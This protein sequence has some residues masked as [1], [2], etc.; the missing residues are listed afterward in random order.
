[1]IYKILTRL[2]KVPGYKY[3]NKNYNKCDL[4]LIY[5]SGPHKMRLAI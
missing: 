5:I 1:M 2:K 4:V 3:E